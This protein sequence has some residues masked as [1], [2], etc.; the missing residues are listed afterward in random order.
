MVGERI[1]PALSS[2]VYV[3][4]MEPHSGKSVVALGLVELLSTRV[5]RVGFF[6]PIVASGTQADGQIELIRRR[7]RLETSYND[8]HGLSDDEGQAAIASGVFDAVEQRVVASYRE[9]ERRSDVVVCEGTDFTGASPA[10]D[11]DMNAGLANLLDVPVLVV[12]SGT[13]PKEIVKSARVARESLERKGC[14]LFGVIANRVPPE[15]L[16][17]VD[18]QLSARFEDQPV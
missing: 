18:G 15:L 14:S 13:D 6:R 11:F 10:L 3:T 8:M 5:E 9:L 17:D 12:V 2:S 16:D 1:R 7:Y 4:A